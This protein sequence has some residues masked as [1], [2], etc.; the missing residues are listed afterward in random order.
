MMAWR[1]TCLL[2]AVALAKP[3][4]SSCIED[5]ECDL[6]ICFTALCKQIVHGD[7]YENDDCIHELCVPK[8]AQCP[9]GQTCDCKVPGTCECLMGIGGLCESDADCDSEEC[10]ELPCWNCDNPC[11]GCPLD[12][13]ECKDCR[14]LLFINAETKQNECDPSCPTPCLPSL[15][16]K[17]CL[18]RAPGRKCSKDANCESNKCNSLGRCTVGLGQ[19]CKQDIDCSTNFCSQLYCDLHFSEKTEF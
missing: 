5:E 17:L 9:H 6:G 18:V 16:N 14:H 19:P 11:V 10:Q 15:C 2:V 13:P 7:C 3:F 1:V 8:P 4:G 12:N